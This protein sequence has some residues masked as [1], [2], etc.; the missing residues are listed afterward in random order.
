MNV[1]GSWRFALPLLLASAGFVVASHGSSAPGA[2]RTKCILPATIVGTDGDDVLTGTPD[3]DFIAGLGG[4]DTIV[5]GGGS[6]AICGGSGNDKITAQDGPSAGFVVVNGGPGD[7]IITMIAND[8]A[9]HNVSGGGGNDT[10][11]C[12][13]RRNSSLSYEDASAAVVVDLQ[14]G[15]ARGGAGTD[16]LTRCGGRVSG[17]AFA[18]VLRGTSYGETLDGRKGNDR[19][20]GRGGNDQFNGGPGNDFVDGGSGQDEATYALEP[21]PAGVVVVDLRRGLSAGVR[22]GV[23][24]DTLLSLE[25]IVGGYGPDVIIG[26]AASNVLTGDDGD[27]RLFGRGGSDTLKGQRGRDRL[28]GGA[29]RDIGD[30]GRSRGD[31]CVSIELRRRCD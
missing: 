23:G 13:T 4:N 8:R 20:F 25:R 16:S 11:D 24:R 3:A 18:D 28:N 26:N 9:L 17:S 15:T 22:A 31:S 30:G 19:L 6:D 2:A 7:D 29:G 5:G 12:G 1:R 14:A 21:R 10:I 27:D